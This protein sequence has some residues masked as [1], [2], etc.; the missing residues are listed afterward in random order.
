MIPNDRFLVDF[1][2]F[3]VLLLVLF[4]FPIREQ[5]SE[6]KRPAWLEILP[7]ITKLNKSPSQGRPASLIRP[8]RHLNCGNSSAV[9]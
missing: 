2:R 7:Y 8:C 5:I 3:S 4:Q 6:G 9:M 1:F